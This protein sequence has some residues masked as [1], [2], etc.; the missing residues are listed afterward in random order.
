[1]TDHYVVLQD[2][3]DAITRWSHKYT[4][5]FEQRLTDA[6]PDLEDR[7]E[8]AVASLGIARL[9]RGGGKGFAEKVIQPNIDAWL[10]RHVQPVIADATAEFVSIAGREPDWAKLAKGTSFGGQSLLRLDDWLRLSALP[11]GIAIG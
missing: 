1:M 10:E 9:A 6:W 3:K 7:L 8:K 11:G 4:A 5:E 2:K